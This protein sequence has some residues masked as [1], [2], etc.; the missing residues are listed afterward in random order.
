MQCR[1]HINAELGIPHPSFLDLG[2][3]N[4][5]GMVHNWC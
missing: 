3:A 5:F 2:E 1:I 4:Y